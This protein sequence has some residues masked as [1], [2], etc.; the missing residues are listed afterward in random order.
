MT[1][2]EKLLEL[3]KRNG[4]SQEEL[5]SQLSVSRQAISRWEIGSSMPDIENVIQLSRLF[6]VSYEYLLDGECKKE[7]PPKDNVQESR[8]CIQGHDASRS[9]SGK[10]KTVGAI[11]IVGGFISGLLS[12]A[13]NK[14][15]LL[16]FAIYML[17][18]GTL[19]LII[20]KHVALI[21]AWITTLPIFL[22]LHNFSRTTMGAIFSSDFYQSSML[23]QLIMAYAM[24]ILL[25]I[26]A[27]LLFF[28]IRCLVKSKQSATPKQK[29]N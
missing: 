20:R 22:F 24:W 1:F 21:I 23:S 17:I 28:T 15:V 10:H 7:A 5:S 25:L 18:C 12:F 8:D 11:L 2:G 14:N 13:L 26:M 3:R 6:G 19:C 4:L 16:L 27:F 9:T 29:N